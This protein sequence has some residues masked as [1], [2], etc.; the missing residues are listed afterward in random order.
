M[1]ERA[2]AIQSKHWH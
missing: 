2:F 1:S